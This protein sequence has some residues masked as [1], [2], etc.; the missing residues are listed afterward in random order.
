METQVVTLDRKKARE[1]YRDYKKHA[2]YSTPIDDEIR[3]AYQLIAQGRMVIKALESIGAAGVNEQ[4]WPKLAIIRAHQ[5]N[6]YFDPD[7][8]GGAG[9]FQPSEWRRGNAPREQIH[10]QIPGVPAKQGKK[11]QAIV[12]QCPLSHRPKR[13]LANYHILWEA[14]WTKIVPR[15]P[16][17]LRRIGKA[18]LWLVVHAWDLTEVERGAL[19]TRIR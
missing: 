11:A 2:H 17:L 8:H 12:P 14:E 16:F 4:G 15:D 19:A 7:Y 10:V 3:R 6:C 9:M 1:L 13:G 5:P 18:D